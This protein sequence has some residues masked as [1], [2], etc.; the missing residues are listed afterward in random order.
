MHGVPL[1]ADEPGWYASTH[2]GKSDDAVRNSIDELLAKNAAWRRGPHGLVS[3]RGGNKEGIPCR[4]IDPDSLEIACD[5]DRACQLDLELTDRSFGKAVSFTG[6]SESEAQQLA[7]MLLRFC[8]FRDPDPSA[9]SA[10]A[11]AGGSGG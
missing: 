11:G 1:K 5:D 3:E 7:A 4:K 6:L 9:A 8:G 2:A 10:E